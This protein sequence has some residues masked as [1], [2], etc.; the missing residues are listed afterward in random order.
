MVTCLTRING[1]LPVNAQG[2]DER[3]AVGKIQQRGVLSF[4]IVDEAPKLLTPPPPLYIVVRGQRF[5]WE[6]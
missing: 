5:V 4:S 6:V 3:T 1:D 2:V